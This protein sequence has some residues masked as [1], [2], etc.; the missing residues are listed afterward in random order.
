MMVPFGEWMPDQPGATGAI[1]DAKNVVPQA[2]GYGPLPQVEEWSDSA[3]ENLNAVASARSP[4]GVL[5]LFAG[6]ATK[7][8]SL[9]PTDKSMDNVSKTG[10]YTTPDRQRWRFAQFGSRVIAANGGARVQGF[11][12]DSSTLF[13]DLAADAP[14]SRYVTV[15][16]DF[17]VCGYDNGSTI[18][19][20]RVQW[21]A[22][23]DE[24]N[25]TPSATTQADYQDIPDAGD[26]RGLTGGE[27]GLVFMERGVVRMSYAGSPLVFQFDTIATGQG[28]LEPNSIIKYAG[29]SYFLS[30][31][32]FYVC[33]G[34]SIKSI[35]TEKVDRW[36][37]NDLDI[38]RTY[39]MSVAVE[40]LRN[41]IVWSYP[42]VDSVQKVIIYNFNLNKWSYGEANI[43][44]IASSTAIASATTAGYTL[45]GLD[46]FGSID[47]LPAS[48][49]SYTWTGGQLLMTG[50]KGAKI[51][52]FSGDPATGVIG[53][54]DLSIN[55]MPSVC[56]LVRP[57]VDNGSGSIQILSRKLLS[58]FPQYPTTTY[59]AN[60]DNRISVRS[61]GNYHRI[62]LTPTG[63]DWKTAI[64]VDVTLVP[65]GVR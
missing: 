56:T 33:D 38:A 28:C 24:T 52:A 39:S 4:T 2:N 16:R 29:I 8:F 48:L 57:V 45:E 44:Y 32:G 63:S 14:K 21:S 26:V 55:G 35:S 47:S 65:Q 20:N 30:E 12:L 41:L 17:V 23:G 15:V 22:L 58:T 9:D 25:W 40:P 53:T 61:G 19:P 46:I 1:T 5:K 62:A 64:G 6:G 42:S 3:S 34:Q 31:D 11:L 27:Y 60:S 18:Y 7:L 36:F 43:D 49:D 51:V 50:V 54:P 37:F 10:N 13:A 59:T